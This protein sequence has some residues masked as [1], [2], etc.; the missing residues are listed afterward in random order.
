MGK[1]I[2]LYKAS[3]TKKPSTSGSMEMVP[4]ATATAIMEAQIAIILVSATQ[5]LAQDFEFTSD[6][7]KKFQELWMANVE[8]N[9]LKK[10]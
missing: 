4:R 10:K 9:Q 6:Q 8:L 2:E 1:L 5:T 7:L 3:E